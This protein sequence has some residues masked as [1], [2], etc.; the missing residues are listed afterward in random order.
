MIFPIIVRPEAEEDIKD[1]FLWYE[2]QSVGLGTECIRCFDASFS[3]ISRTPELHAKIYHDIRRVL[4][5]RF[6]YGVFYVF[7]NNKIF[8]LAV[9]HIK[10][11]P[12]RWQN[13][14]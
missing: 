10:R 7:D 12:R 2:S 6:P 8:I 9:M 1:A 13:R 4:V 11:H 14:F 3:M 5:R